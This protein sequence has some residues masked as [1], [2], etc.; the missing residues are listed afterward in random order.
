M[1]NILVLC[2]SLRI[3]TTS[4][5]IVSST[6]IKLLHDSGYNITVLT[7]SNFDYPVTWLPKEVRVKKFAVSKLQKSIIEK[8]PKVRAMPTYLSG[9]SKSFNNVVSHYKRA[10]KEE[11]LNTKFDLIYVL[12]AGCSFAPHFAISELKLQIPYFVN[13]HDPY[14][15]HLYPDPYK[16]KKTFI[17]SIQEKKFKKVLDKAEGISFPSNLLMDDM[18]KA[19]PIAEKTGF[20]I[21]HIGTFLDNLP[22]SS[23]ESIDLLDKS[24]INI[25][26]AGS[27]LGP[28][29]PK[30]LFKA[31]EE[32]NQENSG[33]ANKVVITFIGTFSKDL[34]DVVSTSNLQNV[35]F[36]NKRFS[37]KES[38]IM[39]AQ[40]D[41]L[42]VIEAIAKHS[43][44]L[45]GKF[46]DIVFAE[47]PL[48]AL[49]PKYSE[50]RI[51]LSDNYEFQTELDN[52]PLI[53]NV[54]LKFYNDKINDVLNKEI[55]IKL[56]SYVSIE[57][58]TKI[59]KKIIG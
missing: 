30:F 29:N 22:E 46:A 11:L 10:I 15:M 58:N 17:S 55:I 39:T 57:A 34:N 43:P 20:V 21:P 23:N 19:F 26:H 33:F 50:V 51:L 45:P 12:G 2:E 5:G 25:I 3:D 14:P 59:I 1:K 6:F 54:L 18:C 35:K 38:L 36:L 8:I 27:L 47:K 32:L 31:V 52:I 42:L 41:A 44:F 9:F 48:I 40:A 13:I 7:E 49:S 53:K 16:T 4:A 56:K 37:Y 24:K 28:R